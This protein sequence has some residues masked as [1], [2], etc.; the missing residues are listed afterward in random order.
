MWNIHRLYYISMFAKHPTIT[1][2]LPTYCSGK[3]PNVSFTFPSLFCQLPCP[4]LHWMT[5]DN[6]SNTFLNSMSF[7]C[8]KAALYKA[9][10]IRYW[11]FVKL[12]KI[13][14]RVDTGKYQCLSHIEPNKESNNKHTNTLT[15]R[16]LLK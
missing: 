10:C 15:A 2:I 9:I 3:E 6:A 11:V 12:G 14:K 4:R 7:S 1:E 5:Q 13:L 16:A 8:V